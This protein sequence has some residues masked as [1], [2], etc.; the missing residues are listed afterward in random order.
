MKNDPMRLAR[1]R[2]YHRIWSEAKRREAG[3]PVRPNKGPLV[4]LV[5]TEYGAE[6]VYFKL[7]KNGRPVV[8]WRKK[9]V[10]P[11]LV[12]VGSQDSSSSS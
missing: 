4:Y 3:K 1:A 11:T 8:N 7:G 6:R 10:D 5:A 9:I 2:E 12:G